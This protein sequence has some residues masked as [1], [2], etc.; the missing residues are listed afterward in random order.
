MIVCVCHQMTLQI[1]VDQSMV[2]QRTVYKLHQTTRRV[3]DTLYVGSR[4]SG[5]RK[6]T[7]PLTTYINIKKVHGISQAHWCWSHSSM[8]QLDYF[9]PRPLNSNQLQWACE[10]YCMTLVEQHTVTHH[11]SLLLCICCIHKK[12]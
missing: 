3:S 1:G 11:S 6:N 2:G 8:N 5:N 12:H 4:I 9:K 7:L 10:G